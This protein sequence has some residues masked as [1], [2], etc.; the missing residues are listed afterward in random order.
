MTTTTHPIDT[1]ERFA[2]VSALLD[3]GGAPRAALLLGAGLDPATWAEAEAH[4]M[5]LLKVDATLAARFAEVYGTTR[6]SMSSTTDA[7]PEPPPSTRSG[8]AQTADAAMSA[9]IRAALP[10]IRA[11]AAASASPSAEPAPAAPSAPFSGTINVPLT[12]LPAP[13][14]PFPLPR[15]SLSQPAPQRPAAPEPVPPAALAE[16]VQ[17]A[18]S[19]AG[20]INLNLQ[21]I[22]SK[23]RRGSAEAP[24]DPTVSA[25]PADSSPAAEPLSGTTD[26]DLRR[27]VAATMPFEREAGP[28]PAVTAPPLPE[29]PPPPAW[30]FPVAGSASPLAGTQDLDART[31]R[32]ALP[33]APGD[34]SRP[35]VESIAGPP[36]HRAAN[37]LS[38][39]ADVS[40]QRLLRPVLAFEATDAA[41]RTE[42]A[43]VAAL[44]PEVPTPPPA[45]APPK[46][47]P[48]QGPEP[49]APLPELRAPALHVVTLAQYAAMLAGVAE[50][51]ELARV[52][53]H[54]GIDPARWPEA[55]ETWAERLADEAGVE[56]ELLAQFD[57]HLAAAQD[58]YGRRLPP[59]DEDLRAWLDF[60]RGW[61]MDADPPALL[62]RTGLRTAEVARLCR[63]WSKRLE[64]D[65]A[66]AEQAQAILSESPS[67]MPVA[68]PVRVELAPAP[69]AKKIEPSAAP[70]PP[71][72]DEVPPLFVPLPSW[73]A[74]E[75]SAE[76]RAQSRPEVKP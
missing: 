21:A 47:G 33:F 45:G 75:A 1:I 38:G 12:F 40:F 52:L 13:T 3:E 37:P 23:L 62:R 66:L 7:A 67:E 4:W 60:R 18:E 32:P 56:S 20:T 61:M 24:P 76:G 73:G 69:A 8:L 27:V 39:T 5:P 54:E 50:G 6:R 9:Q 30:P 34:P 57:E 11:S 68:A 16:A 65:P 74:R 51:H 70:E 42:L 22:L 31:V 10:F 55:E 29:P 58:R 72:E 35:P 53:A 41:G 59:L 17:D 14:L 36:V 2:E 71:E 49:T 25:P 19:L 63:F 44:S 64:V 48:P 46:L 43:F 15:A 26:L 28:S